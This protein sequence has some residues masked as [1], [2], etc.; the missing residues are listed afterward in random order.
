MVDGMIFIQWEHYRGKAEPG[1][2]S[3]DPLSFNSRQERLHSLNK[4]DRL[5]LVSRCPDDRQYYF[6]AVLAVA[7]Q[8]RNE[9]KSGE[10]QA[11]GEYGLVADRT[12]SHDLG[13]RF[14][15]EGFLRALQFDPAKPIKYGASLGQ[16]LQTLR[17]LSDYPIRVI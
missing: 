7:G 17:L 5:W 14:P 6:V 10:A 12:T 13:T 9:P 3:Q 1:L 16:S 15:A 2:F 11:F 8:R 4:G